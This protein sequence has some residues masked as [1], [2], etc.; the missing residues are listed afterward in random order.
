LQQQ[1]NAACPPTLEI[2][3]PTIHTPS[4]AFF[5]DSLPL[6]QTSESISITKKVLPV[7]GRMTFDALSSNWS[8]KEAT[9]SE[10]LKIASERANHQLMCA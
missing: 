1:E 4:F 5:R 9:R 2:T 7:D 6:I 8:M 3:R 10:Q